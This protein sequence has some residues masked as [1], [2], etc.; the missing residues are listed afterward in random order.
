[1]SKAADNLSAPPL[2]PKGFWINSFKSALKPKTA[3]CILLNPLPKAL[4]IPKMVAPTVAST[5]DKA[6]LIPALTTRNN[7]DKALTG[8]ATV[9]RLST[10]L[11]TQSRLASK[12]SDNAQTTPL[13]AKNCFVNILF[14]N[15][16][17]ILV[18][19]STAA[20]S[21][22]LKLSARKDTAF[23]TFVNVLDDFSNS[24]NAF[25]KELVIFINAW[26][27]VRGIFLN[28]ASNLAP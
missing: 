20:N 8:P 24:P 7:P 16:T 6:F 21:K 5:S 28:S 11:S 10:K 15:T 26:P 3:A 19:A 2:S 1:M 22:T 14:L 4:T 23:A 27:I 9:L 12:A 18:N 13:K 25:V 17:A